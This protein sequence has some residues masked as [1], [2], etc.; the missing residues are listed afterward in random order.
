MKLTAQQMVDRFNAKLIEHHQRT[1]IIDYSGTVI[2]LSSGITFNGTD[3]DRFC[4]RL[5]N[6]KTT[7]WA[8]NVD[9][10]LNGDITVSDIKSKL[11]S[12]GGKAVQ[13][14]HGDSIRQNLNTGR[15]WNAGTKGQHIGTKGPLPQSVKDKISLKNSGENNG[16]FGIKMSDEDKSYRSELMKQKILNGEFT[17]NSNNRN[18]HWKSMFDGKAYRSS[19]EALY[20]YINQIAEYETLRIEYMF[21]KKTMIYIVDFVDHINKLVVEV[22]PSRM[23]DGNKFNGKMSALSKWADN[24]GYSVLVA[25]EKWFLDQTHAI[26]Y[27]RFDKKTEIKI[28]KLYE[29]NKKDRN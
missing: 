9:N 29:T 4:N 22:K 8:E 3:K 13:E 11:S 27:E 26:D 12:I 20:Q 7:L 18:T 24:N 16:M 6:S 1:R 25:T 17:P 2:V 21:D 28:R 19:W 5:M 15:P 10:L 23:C 14:K